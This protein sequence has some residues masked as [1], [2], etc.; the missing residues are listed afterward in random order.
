MKVVM[1][2]KGMKRCFKEWLILYH[3]MKKVML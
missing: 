2:L 3:E 1:A